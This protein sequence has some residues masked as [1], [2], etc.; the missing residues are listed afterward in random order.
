[1]QPVT[2][3]HVCI[4][5]CIGTVDVMFLGSSIQME[6][7]KW[8]SCWVAQIRRSICSERLAIVF[9]HVGQQ[10]IFISLTVRL[11]MWWKASEV[12]AGEECI[13]KFW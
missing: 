2:C 7:W 5:N 8:Y 6:V 11:Y 3:M 13:C 12:E 10:L 1:M 4:N 9:L